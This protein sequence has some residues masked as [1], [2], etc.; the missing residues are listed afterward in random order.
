MLTT[1]GIRVSESSPL[2]NPLAEVDKP[3][4]KQPPKYQVLLLNDDFTPMDFV[5]DI[6]RRFFHKSENDATHIMLN[7]HQQGRGLCGIYPRE[8]AESKVTQV[9]QSSRSNGHPLACIMQ[10]DTGDDDAE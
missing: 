6:L 10:K 1:M 2:A 5:V 7:V 8:I 3:K 9:R 4:L